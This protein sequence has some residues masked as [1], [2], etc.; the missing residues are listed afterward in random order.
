MINADMTNSSDQ[1][2]ICTSITA[3]ILELGFQ[4]VPVTAQGG[5]HETTMDMGLTFTIVC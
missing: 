4:K 3:Y 5:L 2:L 1:L